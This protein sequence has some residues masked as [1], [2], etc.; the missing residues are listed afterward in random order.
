MSSPWAGGAQAKSKLRPSVPDV[1]FKDTGGVRADNTVVCQQVFRAY[2]AVQ[3]LGC[4]LA[5][6]LRGGQHCLHAQKNAQLQ[7]G[8]SVI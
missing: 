3:K 8:Q 5:V 2:Q 6:S 4:L 7:E 1:R